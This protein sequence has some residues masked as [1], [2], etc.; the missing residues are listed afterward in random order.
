MGVRVHHLKVSNLF[1]KNYSYLIV[2]SASQTA[3][4]VDPAWQ[5]KIIDQKLRQHNATLAAVLLTHSHFD[6]G[7][8]APQLVDEHNCVVMMSKIEIDYYGYRSRNL[9]AIE[10]FTSFSLGG[11]QILPILTPGHTKGSLCYLIEE[12][13]F[14][15]DTLFSEGCGMCWGKGADPYA[16]YDS[17]QYLKGA[18]K[19]STR[20]Y[21]GHSYGEKP[22]QTFGKLMKNNI[23]LLIKDREFFVKFRMRDNQTG[24]FRFS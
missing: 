21:P 17:I 16:M 20:I 11:T 22:G 14:T 13:L 5:K 9:Q 10:D 15:G 18:L 7:N 23:Y 3:V 19:M 8:L 12:N 24:L 6:H 1:F 2:D 4:I